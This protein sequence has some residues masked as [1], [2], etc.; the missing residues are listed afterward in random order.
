M[1]DAKRFAVE[2]H[3]DQSYGEEPYAVHLEAVVSIV[4]QAAPD[5]ALA[6]A[7][8]WLHDVV[9]DTPVTVDALTKSFG[10]E[11][12]LAVASLSDPPGRSR[13]ER[14][15]RLHE[16]LGTLDPD[17]PTHRVTLLVKA[18]DRLAN[19]RACV[20]AGDGRLGMYR[21]EH[22]EFRAAA[23]RPGLCDAVWSELDDLLRR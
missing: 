15:A 7:V 17:S 14:K 9:E 10:A 4:Q 1:S 11:V 5:D 16:H 23:H 21:T 12:A 13:R 8:A 2:A 19:V 6:E 18:A 22:P 3:A 20:A